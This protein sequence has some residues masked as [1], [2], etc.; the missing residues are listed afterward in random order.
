MWRADDLVLQRVV[1][2]PSLADR[3]CLSRQNMHRAV[4]QTAP[5][6]PV[7]LVASICRLVQTLRYGYSRGM[8]RVLKWN[9]K[10]VPEELRLLP[11]GRYVVEAVDEPP[12]LTPEEEEGLVQAL[13]ALDRGE[14]ESAREVRRAIS[15]ALKR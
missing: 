11:A 14:R 5:E 7:E 12:A 2:A 10:D 6:M 4:L 3:V 13:R 1:A 9:G 8:S 15:K